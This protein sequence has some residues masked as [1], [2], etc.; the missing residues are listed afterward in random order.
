MRILVSVAC[1]LAVAGAPALAQDKAKD[2]A[3]KAAAP[4]KMSDDDKKKLI[5][6]GCNKE[7]DSMK[8]KGED[9]KSFLAACLKE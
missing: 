1:L 4:G 2:A 3:K 5:T 8:L 7:A 9:R 6:A